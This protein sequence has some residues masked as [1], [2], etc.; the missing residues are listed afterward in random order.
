[1]SRID[2]VYVATHRRD[3]RFTRICIASIR[4]WYPDIPIF[5]LKDLVN[6]DFSTCELEKMWNVRCWPTTGEKFGWGFVKLEPLFVAEPCRYLML[7][8]DIVILGRVID[9]LEKSDAD[10]VV[11][12][13]TQPTADIPSLYFD[14]ARLREKVDTSFPGLGFTFNSGQYVAT[15]GKLTREDF[16]R[17]LDWTWPRRV[18]YPEMFNPGDQGVLN[19]VVLSKLAAGDISVDRIPFMRW[20]AQ[21]TR[22]F[23]VQALRAQSPYPYVIHWAGLKKMRLRTMMRA[24]I[25]SHFER[26]YYSRIQFGTLVRWFRIIQA[27][28]ER[29]VLRFSRQWKR[30]TS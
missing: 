4:R 1:M 26:S 3:L 19:Y 12:L 30:L 7:D 17:V 27:E 15:S 28:V 25:L 11:Q 22:D 21:E 5:L 9:E 14:E 8:S 18:R 10:F 23:D 20:S 2:R 16:G 29:W 6:G 13:E 24:D